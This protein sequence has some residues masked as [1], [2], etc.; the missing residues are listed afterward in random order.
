MKKPL[1]LICS[2]LSVGKWHE[3]F[4][5]P[6]IADVMLARLVSRVHRIDLKGKV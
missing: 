4:D 1:P 5:E 2:R 6:T 3:Y